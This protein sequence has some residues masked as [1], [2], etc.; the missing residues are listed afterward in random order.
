MP[1]SRRHLKMRRR[2]TKKMRKRGGQVETPLSDIS[3]NS[4]MHDLDDITGT[5]TEESTLL[6]ESVASQGSAPVATNLLGQFNAEAPTEELTNNTT[7]ETR[8]NSFSD[9]ASSFGDLAQGGK[10][11]T[12]TNKKKRF[13]IHKKRKT[14][15]RK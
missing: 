4:S 15:K 1:K 9:V 13:K 6:D 14:Y 5:T 10:R 3:T 8:D 12:R 7:A 2:L 11:K